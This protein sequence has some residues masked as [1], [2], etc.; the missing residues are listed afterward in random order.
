MSG[1]FWQLYGPSSTSLFPGAIVLILAGMLLA[2]C[3]L[4]APPAEQ[5]QRGLSAVPPRLDSEVSCELPNVDV[6]IVHAA[7]AYIHERYPVQPWP[8]DVYL[9]GDRS[10]APPCQDQPVHVVLCSH[11]T[12]FVWEGDVV[13]NRS[14]A[15]CRIQIAGI[16]ELF[17]AMPASEVVPTVGP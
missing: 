4:I 12:G 8:D 7:W 6:E 3:I 13:W 11:A 17:V 14:C 16:R 2:G 5:T 15:C 9:V 1:R 10:A